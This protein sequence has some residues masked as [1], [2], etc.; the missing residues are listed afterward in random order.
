MDDLALANGP[1]GGGNLGLGQDGHR[2]RES[3]STQP[4]FHV[5]TPQSCY[6]TVL[7]LYKHQS[8]GWRRKNSRGSASIVQIAST[9]PPEE[10]N[11]EP[12][13]EKSGGL[14]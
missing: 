7:P 3:V 12:R 14:L 2:N 11:M 9:G 10:E 6:E 5:S 13:H 1:I 4:D 8:G